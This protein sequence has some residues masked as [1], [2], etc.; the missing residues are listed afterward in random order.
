M[1]ELVNLVTATVQQNTIID[2]LIEPRDER[3]PISQCLYRAANAE[4]GV[5]SHL[6]TAGRL[7]TRPLC[8]HY[9]LIS[10]P[11]ER[12]QKRQQVQKL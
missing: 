2:K 7:C 5:R 11:T 9:K 8:Y 10:R 3:L 12:Q 4:C 1:I 6:N